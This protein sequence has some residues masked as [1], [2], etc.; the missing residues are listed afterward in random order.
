MRRLRIRPISA[1]TAVLTI[2]TTVAIVLGLPLGSAASSPQK[3]F[4][5][6]F[7]AQCVLAPGVLNQPG[8]V[9]F[10]AHLR[11]PEEV[12]SG[13]E[14]VY[15]EPRVTITMPTSWTESFVALGARE[16]RTRLT[17]FQLDAA[18]MQPPTVN[19]AGSE[20]VIPVEK[21]KTTSFVS[22]SG[23]FAEK[24]T[25]AN[26]EH[27]GLSVDASPGFEELE[28]SNYKETGAGIVFTVE[29]LTSSGEHL[30]GPLVVTCNA[31]AGVT[32]A[33]YVVGPHIINCTTTTPRPLFIT[34]EPKQGPESGGTEVTIGGEVG[35]VT[36]V[37]FGPT[38]VSFQTSM[39][40]LKVV[41]P[42][43][44]GAVSVDVTAPGDECGNGH[45]GEATFTYTT[46][47]EKLKQTE[48]ALAGS[49]TDKKLGQAITLP[50]GSTFNGSGELNAGTGAGAET[51]T[52]SIP[53]FSASLKLFGVL[54]VNLGLSLT[55]S[56]PI[57]GTIAKSETVAGDERLSLPIA[58][59]LRVTSVGVL[60]L[61]IPT[62]CATAEPLALGL[63]A[64]LTRE[65]LLA[66]GWSFT[67]A[68]TLARFQCEGGLLGPLFGRVLTRLL[69]GE[70]NAYAISIKPPSG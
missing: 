45:H 28:P 18:G 37:T 59:N 7:E 39:S 67:G 34:L 66:T 5:S 57:S 14:V 19:L 16:L 8:A 48:W 31:P 25:A 1:V 24:V 15:S 51:G 3:E 47:T 33:S 58:L 29:A 50:A 60:G 49:I 17:H 38:K 26:G 23:S 46:T 41:S 55:Q 63:V 11:G 43:G 13:E 35:S 27:A 53:P 9:K 52:V 56:G 4:S 21:G 36:E 40:G 70:E 42:P 20:E 12:R 22:S 32:L 64:N 10:A 69:S 54:P 61:N 65:E 68:A 6:S 30:A 62:S 44:H 2:G